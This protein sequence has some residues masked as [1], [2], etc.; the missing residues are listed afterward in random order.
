MFCSSLTI[1]LDLNINSGS[2]VFAEML[3]SFY[4]FIGMLFAVMLGIWNRSRWTM[5]YITG[6]VVQEVY[7]TD[8][9][10]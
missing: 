6:T 10:G 7:R 4:C 9:M 8:V 2:F 1:P 3:S 5:F